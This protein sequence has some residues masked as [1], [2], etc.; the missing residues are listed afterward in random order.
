M[1][2]KV[3]TREE[4]GIS[5]LSLSLSLYCMSLSEQKEKNIFLCVWTIIQLPLL[6]LQLLQVNGLQIPEEDG[7]PPQL[8]YN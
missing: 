4:E 7:P 6:T 1:N 3:C 8:T 5:S 2:Y